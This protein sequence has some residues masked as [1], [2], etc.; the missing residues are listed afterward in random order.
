M[1][2]SP[3]GDGKGAGHP[4]VHRILRREVALQDLLPFQKA[5]VHHRQEIQVHQVVGVKDTEGVIAFV[6]SKNFGKYPV[7]GVALAHQLFVFSFE[8]MS[9]VLPRDVRRIVRAVVC[10][11][12]DVIELFRIFQKLQI[13]QK[14]A[15]HHGFIMSR[16]D[17]GEFA[18]RRCQ[19]F[20]FSMPHA[21]EC[22]D[23]VVDRED[24]HNHLHRKH[25]Y[26]EIVVH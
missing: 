18:L 6:Q 8:N 9:T 4:G 19:I 11:E 23:G 7:H 13:F 17:D 2:D 5:I 1:V 20:F 22:D 15:D 24:P 26:I 21:K 25:D 12:V 16:D 3:E 14:V 10:D